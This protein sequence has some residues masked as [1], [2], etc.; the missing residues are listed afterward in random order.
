MR[1]MP[2]LVALTYTPDAEHDPRSRQPRQI[3]GGSNTITRG[4]Y[5]HI[6]GELTL[7]SIPILLL[8]FCVP[9]LSLAAASLTQH[10]ITWTFDADY[11]TGQFVNGDYWVVDPGGGVK[12]VNINPGFTSSPRDKNGSMVNPS[13]APQ[14]YD[15]TRDYSSAVNVGVGISAGTPLV[16]RSGSS[17]VSTISVDTVAD[18]NA[19]YVKT[20]AV[21]TCLSSIP[22]AGSFRPGI[23]GT[24]KTLHN[25]NNLNL[26][27][28]QKLVVPAGQNVTAATLAAYSNY[29]KM[30]W[31][32]HYHNYTAR[33]MHPVDSGLDNYYFPIK[34][35]EAALML[36]LKFTD[37]EKDELLV[38]YIQLGID[39][40][41][42]L[43]S[44]SPGWYPNGG[45]SSGR[46]WPILFAGIM[47][48]YA[49]MKNIG[50]V[51]GN[52]LYSE[53]YGPG[54]PPSNYK[55][56]SEDDQT[57]YV[58][59]FDIDITNQP[60]WNGSTCY[61]G[62]WCPD[63]RSLS[64]SPYSLAL[65]GMPEWGIKHSMEPQTSNSSWKAKYRTID[66]GAPAWA[67][68]A[69]AARLMRAQAYWNHKPY[70]DYVDRYMAITEGKPD[71]FGY[72]VVEENVEGR[73]VGLVGTMWD[74]YRQDYPCP[75]Y[76]RRLF[77]N[78]RVGEV[79]Q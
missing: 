17:L 34:W 41:S 9:S 18:S 14:G 49:P 39:L 33:N 31:L 61:T 16:L 60:I 13:T 73:P 2:I 47:L 54:N 58:S 36:H 40:Y 67:G 30:V 22:P 29:F 3:D 57:F 56:F 68:T 71:P 43:E 10:G 24:S 76:T 55:Y 12:I 32:D 6:A 72:M 38:N 37:A 46:K 20:A 15:G 69:L 8:L 65:Q 75:P 4:V 70:F 28:L 62:Q 11:V 51:S 66:S 78:V 19:S 48:D 1:I 25:K 5:I 23:S 74:A 7:K 27:S 52:Y 21:L 42:Y 64:Y 44:G 79:E 45:H 63:L 59:Q 35:A 53:G 26:S 77:R 50:Q